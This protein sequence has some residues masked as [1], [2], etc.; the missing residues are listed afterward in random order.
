MISKIE[1]AKQ[2]S[3]YEGFIK[4]SPATGNMDLDQATVLH[5]V[6]MSL[7][8]GGIINKAEQVTTTK[9]IAGDNFG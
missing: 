4:E 7:G 5:Q 1:I 8:P 6:K 9:V 3:E 2:T